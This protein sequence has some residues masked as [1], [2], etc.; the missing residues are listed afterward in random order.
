MQGQIHG[1]PER[2]HFARRIG[3]EVKKSH[4]LESR[5]ECDSSATEL[6]LFPEEP[7]NAQV[8]SRTRSM[9]ANS[10]VKS[11]IRTNNALDISSSLRQLSRNM[12]VVHLVR[13]SHS[14]YRVRR[15]RTESQH[16]PRSY[17]LARIIKSTDSDKAQNDIHET[18]S[19]QSQESDEP[20]CRQQTG[21]QQYRKRIG[22]IPGERMRM[23]A[24]HKRPVV[25]I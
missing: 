10:T 18:Q 6:N 16:R 14:D 19:D 5:I 15:R 25:R 20:P 12:R 17:L 3:V 2:S 1:T 4:K 24:P 11:S 7:V 23:M 13:F 22:L 8:Q 21:D 9:R